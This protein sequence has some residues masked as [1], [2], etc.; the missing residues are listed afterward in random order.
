M[1]AGNR[2]CR[3]LPVQGADIAD[4]SVTLRT[5]ETRLSV[6]DLPMEIVTK[7]CNGNVLSDG[8]SVIVNKTLNVKG[9]A[10]SLKKGTKIK[11]IRLTDDDGEV[12]CRIGKSTIVLRTEFLK[13]A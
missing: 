3:Q 1:V 12:E 2:T 13:K 7:D 9:S 10:I 8:D 11:G 6:R 5:T 4:Y